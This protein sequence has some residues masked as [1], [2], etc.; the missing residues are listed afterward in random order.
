MAVALVTGGTSG[1]GAEFARQLAIRGYDLVLVARDVVR[2][3]DSATEFR[4]LGAQVEILPA[5]LADRSD[6]DAVAARLEDASRPIDLLVN[7]AGFGIHV[8]LTSKDVSE[9]DRGF[10][11][12]CRALLVLSGAAARGMRDRGHGRIVNISSVAG[13]LSMGSYSTVKSWVTTFTESL[14]VELRGTGVTATAVL[15]GWVRTE[16]HQRA[17]IRSSSI[18]NSLWLSAEQLVSSALRDVEKGK[19][20]SIPTVRYQ[21]LVWMLRHAP[22]GAV[23]SVSSAISSSRKTPAADSVA[24]SAKEGL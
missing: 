11:V 20:L 22:A 12:M 18:P 10:D 24:S 17:G 16:F 6:V 4:A 9:H 14:S 7:N 3:D 2:L 13:M 1:I 8:P 19:V 5:D 21:A 15:P 23:R